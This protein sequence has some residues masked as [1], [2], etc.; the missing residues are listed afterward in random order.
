MT[1]DICPR[2]SFSSPPIHSLMLS[3]CPSFVCSLTFLYPLHLANEKKTK[4]RINGVSAL[5]Q[6]KCGM[7][8]NLLAQDKRSAKITAGKRKLHHSLILE[9]GESGGGQWKDKRGVWGGGWRGLERCDRVERDWGGSSC[10]PAGQ[11]CSAIGFVSEWR[12]LWMLSGMGSVARNYMHI[13]INA[14][15][16]NI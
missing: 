3:H 13:R 16:S 12:I 4:Q 14:Q 8:I 9:D 11:R 5:R 7:E 1:T 2:P 6:Q 10:S 15:E